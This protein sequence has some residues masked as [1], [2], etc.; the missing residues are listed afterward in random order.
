MSDDCSLPDSYVLRIRSLLSGAS[1]TASNDRPM[2]PV[3]RRVLLGIVGPPGAGKSTLSARLLRHFGSDV[4]QVLPMDGYHLANV[5]LRRLGR[6]DR[7]GAP[8]TFDAAGFLQLLRRIRGSDSEQ[9]ADDGGVIYAPEF[10]REIE[11]PIAGAIAIHPSTQL[12]IVEGN[13]LLLENGHWAGVR[14]LLSEVWYVDVPDALRQKR[15]VRFV[16]VVAYVQRR[17]QI[18]SQVA[19]HMRYGRSE[20]EAVAWVRDTDE[21]NAR[22]IAA[23]KHRA[24]VLFQWEEV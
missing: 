1:S 21:P 9:Q 23:G 11:E 6:L 18:P 7:K 16:P 14:P 17:S 2:H 15:L 24:H 13:Y 12:V 19:R 5:E 8:D 10:R 20:A 4:A 3:T 22:L